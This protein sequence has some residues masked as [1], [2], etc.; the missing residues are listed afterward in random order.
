MTATRES[1]ASAKS[2]YV[3]PFGCIELR[4]LRALEARGASAST[5]HVFMTLRV[6]AGGQPETW[7]S[8]RKLAQL[9]GRKQL[10]VMTAIDWLIERGIVAVVEWTGRG[11]R[12][13][14]HVGRFD[15]WP[16]NAPAAP[17]DTEP[18]QISSSQS[19]SN[20]IALGHHESASNGVAP[21]LHS[22][23]QSAAIGTGHLEREEEDKTKRGQGAVISLEPGA[24]PALALRGTPASPPPPEAKDVDRGPDRDLLPVAPA[25]APARAPASAMSQ[26]DLAVQEALGLLQVIGASRADPY[27][28]DERKDGD[29]LRHV[30]FQMSDRAGR[31][32]VPLVAEVQKWIA[33]PGRTVEGRV[34]FQRAAMK[35]YLLKWDPEK[36]P[37]WRA[38][39]PITRGLKRAR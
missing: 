30:H 20:G 25:R 32:D 9:T 16:S 18:A 12:R 1:K 34:R 2:D 37:A 31:G 14:L 24:R 22:G 27:D 13:T 15:E 36:D 7:W 26:A 10:T 28:Y 23:Q 5:L 33:R 6:C 17:D 8:V 19:A 35:A 39:A 21:V 29:V 3:A 4:E 38:S 11:S